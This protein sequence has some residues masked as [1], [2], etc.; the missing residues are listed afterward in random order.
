MAPWLQYTLSALALTTPSRPDLP[1]LSRKAFL[2]GSAAAAGLAILGRPDAANAG[3]GSARVAVTTAPPIKGEFQSLDSLEGLSPGKRRQVESTLSRGQVDS[4]SQDLEARIEATLSRLQDDARAQADGLR[5]QQDTEQRLR[6]AREKVER[7]Q[8]KQGAGDK[9]PPSVKRGGK[10][11]AG[12]KGGE[13][14]ADAAALVSQLED[15]LARIKRDTRA[16]IEQR[17]EEQ[18]KLQDMLQ[19]Q[20]RLLDQLVRRQ[21]LLAKLDAQPEWFNYAA[22]FGASCVSTLV[23][24]PIDTLKI[25]EMAS[26]EL[27]P[28]ECALDLSED[29][30]ESGGG[31]GGGGG[32]GAGPATERLAASWPPPS[33]GVAGEMGGAVGTVVPARAAV[34]E[35]AA[36]PA[37]APAPAVLASLEE[38]GAAPLEVSAATATATVEVAGASELDGSDPLFDLKRR[39]RRL[40]EMAA[41]ATAIAEEMAVVEAPRGSEAHSSEVAAAVEVAEA[42]I[43]ATAEAATTAD[44]ADSSSSKKG[45]WTLEKYLSLYQGLPAALAKEGPPSAVY[46]GVYEAAKTRLLATDLLGPFPLLVSLLAGAMGETFGSLLRAPA[47]AIKSRV[48][49][50]ADATTG[51]SFQSV[52]GTPEG[53]ENVQRAWSA[54]LFRDVPFGAIQ[55]A[56]FESLKAFLINSP[57]TGG[58]NV[59][60]L[61]AEALLGAIGGSIGAFLTTPPDVV[62]V[63]ILTQETDGC[64]DD[65]EVCRGEPRGF[66]EMADEIIKMDGPGGLLTGWQ[67]RTGYWAPAIGIFLSCFCGIRQFAVAMNWFQ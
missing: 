36:A 41:A 45:E 59:D 63:R 51:E 44:S 22:A 58:I 28:N 57:S 9:K 49:S 24:H 27:P 30:G 21:E 20:R 47:E 11:A 64:S 2:K 35:Q 42:K 37:G 55:L 52:L 10:E 66:G 39:G 32:G 38:M 50:G 67:A 23:M 33:N 62:T 14:T 65:T 31:S 15:Q 1:K 60:T 6:A 17:Q 16:S 3:L 12:G 46:L 4:L 61:Q 13:E 25:Q 40:E 34:V 5:L 18:E 7:A 43:T 26:K 56:V 48:Q 29:D 19:T 8:A 54:S 53:R